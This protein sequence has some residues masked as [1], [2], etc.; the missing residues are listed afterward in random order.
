MK[1]DCIFC[2][3]LNKQLSSY[4][5]FENQEIMA[6]LDNRPL[7]PGHTLVIPKV[8]IETIFEL[9][10]HLAQKLFQASKHIAIAVKKAM[11]AEGIFIGNNNVIGQTV[12]HFHLHV[13]PRNKGDGLK[14][15]F[16]PRNPYSTEQ[17]ISE[18]QLKIQNVLKGLNI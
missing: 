5:I 6:F 16:W 2:K 13:V 4:Q 3:I 14:G 7:F 15:F 10:D 9:E 18:T 17:E 8:H 1:E 11:G 12:P